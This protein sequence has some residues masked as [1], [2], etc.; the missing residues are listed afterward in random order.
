MGI[1]ITRW[2]ILLLLLPVLLYTIWLYKRY[3]GIVTTKD[4]LIAILRCIIMT[5]VI[6]ALSGLEFV[7]YSNTTSIIFVVDRSYSLSTEKEKAQEFIQ[8]SLE[9]KI[10]K[11]H[12]GIATFGTNA[13]VEHPLAK[14]IDFSRIETVPEANFTNMEAGLRLGFSMMEP[15][16]NRRI[17]LISDGAENVGDALSYAGQLKRHDTIVDTYYIPTGV[18][19]DM[20]ITSIDLP[21]TI[22]KGEEYDI[23]V[24]IDSNI[25]IENVP[26]KLYADKELIATDKL[27]IQR[28]QNI[29]LFRHSTD[30]TGIIGYEA[31]IDID[32]YNLDNNQMAGFTYVEGRPLVGIVEGAK[33]SADEI[34][35]VLNAGDVDYNLID[36]GAFPQTLDELRRYSGLILANVSLEDLRR[37]SEVIIE[38][39]VEGLGRGLMVIGGDNS[40]A[41]GGYE[42]SI[43]EEILPLSM[44]ISSKANIPNLG[45]ILVIDR[46]ASMMEG[47][48]GITR[49]DL[50]KEA[51]IKSVETLRPVDTVG[52]VAFDTATTWVVEPTLAKDREKIYDQIATLRTGGGT[53]MYPGLVDAYEALNKIDAKLKHI[54]ALSDGQSMPAPY[55]KILEKLELE[56][57]TL[58]TVALGQGADKAFLESIAMKGRGRY[59]YADEFSN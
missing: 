20:Q 35:S 21:R 42:G 5:L 34:K 11:F 18:Q 39:F 47:I 33:G 22:Y 53:D 7:R 17:V 44:D 52:V 48:G 24:Y 45:L 14:D 19:N 50:A 43:L 41:L 12:V 59:Y 15:D 25:A 40:F 3:N 16:T 23:K 8:K 28:G 32:D 9:H 27:N 1:N 30:K 36:V 55:E 57:I 13:L 54:I 6:L 10:D 29:F 46:S 2:P 26:L 31:R 38:N 37:D 56:D 58:S 49:L 4:R 51:A